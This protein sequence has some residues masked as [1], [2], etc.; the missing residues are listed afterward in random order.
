MGFGFTRFGAVV[1]AVAGFGAPVL[2]QDVDGRQ[3][4]GMARVFTNDTIADRKD[5]WRSGGYGISAFRGPEWSGTLPSQPFS[6]M[7]YR[8]RGEVMAPDN[9]TR[10]AA[11]DRLYAGSLWLG[12]HTHLAWQGLDVTA[13]ADV[14]V[15]GEQSGVRQ[16]QSQ[17]HDW[18]SM[19]RM[20]VEN[21]QVA[22]GV[23]LHGTVE[24]AKAVTLSWG[25]LRPFAELQAGVENMA[26]AGVD[27]TIGSLGQ[28]GLRARDPITGQRI[29]GIVE[30]GASGWSF[31]L[32]GDV[33][34]VD[35]SIFLPESRGYTVEQTRQRMRLGAN[36]A[37][38][39]SNFFYG[40]TYMSEEFVGQSEGQ[41]VGSLSL[42]LRF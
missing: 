18:F 16:L 28:A 10:P 35:S 29:A 23:Y 42:N 14:V 39:T 36:Y 27:L 21:F 25:E 4:L 31:L 17:I 6:V 11:G 30:T 5:R 34:H 1:I 8:L 12:A 13:G 33:A 19:P 41:L 32:G 3:S 22:N 9:L 26:R 15:T 38:G 7:E 24:M 37:V 40:V 2:A 20:D